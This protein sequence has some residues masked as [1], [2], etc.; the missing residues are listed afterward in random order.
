MEH[1][2]AGKM[3]H[4]TSY[5]YLMKGLIHSQD[6]VKLFFRREIFISY[7]GEKGDLVDLFRNLCR[8]IDL[9]KFYYEGMW[10][11]LMATGRTRWEVLYY[12]MQQKFREIQ[13]KVSRVTLGVLVL[14]SVLIGILVIVLY[15]FISRHH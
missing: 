6:D 2:H 13:C 1:C 14:V 10:E 4:I 12:K 7:V 11:Q 9:D 15:F 3:K 8:N 5:V